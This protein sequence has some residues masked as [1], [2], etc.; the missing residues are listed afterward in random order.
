[1][2]SSAISSSNECF[3]ACGAASVQVELG[4]I[5]QFQFF[6]LDGAAQFRHQ[7]Q[8]LAPVFVIARVVALDAR[9]A[10]FRPEHGDIG[11]AQ[12]F[13]RFRAVARIKDSCRMP[14]VAQYL[15]AEPDVDVAARLNFW[16]QSNLRNA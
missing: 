5:V 2:P 15:R 3:D 16:S 6:A 9:A 4:L 14:V 7:C 11:A 10:L 12:Q 13:M 1:M 8:T